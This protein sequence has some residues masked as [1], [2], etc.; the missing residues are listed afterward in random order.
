MLD[1]IISYS[2]LPAVGFIFVH[3]LQSF[4]VGENENA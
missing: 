1:Q 2:I 4:M 3:N